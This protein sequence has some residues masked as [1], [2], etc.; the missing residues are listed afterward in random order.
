MKPYLRNG[1]CVK[2]YCLF[3]GASFITAEL[4]MSL[5]GKLKLRTEA[6]ITCNLVSWSSTLTRQILVVPLVMWSALGHTVSSTIVD[7]SRQWRK[8][9]VMLSTR[10]S[11]TNYT[12]L[13]VSNRPV[14]R[15]QKLV[16]EN[17]PIQVRI[18]RAYWP[19]YAAIITCMY[20]YH[21]YLSLSRDFQPPFLSSWSLKQMLFTCI[22]CIILYGQNTLLLCSSLMC[23]GS[24]LF[25]LFNIPSNTTMLSPDYRMSCINSIVLLNLYKTPCNRDLTLLCL[26]VY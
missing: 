3:S 2:W 20:T 17:F 10:Y 24:S 8:L 15:N 26:T 11:R 13:F 6:I 23:A 1:Y 25:G 9:F 19:T 7:S 4:M 14:V 16:P 22:V 18:I 5:T 21:C 12:F